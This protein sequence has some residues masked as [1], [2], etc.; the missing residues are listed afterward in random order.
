MSRK[1][2]T[3]E[4]VKKYFEDNGCT[5]LSK[6]YKNYYSKLDYICSCGNTS[7]TCFYSFKRGH[8]CN[9]CAIVKR[10]NKNRLSIEYVKDR[11]SVV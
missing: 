8:R 3:L 6:E 10:A 7:K 4:Y 2:L 9:K 11:K 5:L 1:S